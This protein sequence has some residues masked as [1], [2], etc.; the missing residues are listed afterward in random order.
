MSKQNSSNTRLINIAI[1][2]GIVAIAVAL[3]IAWFLHS[4]SSSATRAIIHDGDG[5]EYELLLSQDTQLEVSTSLGTNIIE[6]HD[7]KVRVTSA[8]CPNKTCVNQGWISSADE[9]II[10]LPHKLTV[11]IESDSSEVL[12]VQAR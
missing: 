11:T 5:K 4:A 8:D 6:V 2:V 12:D 9:Q 1:T 3:C 10:C 7:G